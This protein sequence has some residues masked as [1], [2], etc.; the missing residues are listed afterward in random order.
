MDEEV[1]LA[2][3]VAAVFGHLAEPAR[4]GDW[5]PEVSMVLADAATGAGIGTGF[6]LWLCRDG[7]KLSGTGELI[8]Y[9]PPWSVAYRLR[10]GPHIHVLRL[11]CT[12]SGGATRVHVHQA[13]D[14]KLLAVD[15]T[16]LR[17]ALAGTGP[18][19]PDTP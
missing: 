3:P 1:M 4:L 11:T 9:E 18:A 17:Q 7:Q 14:A 13:G 8:A 6:G 10:A 15:L 16:G 5:L 2:H 12:V 19:P